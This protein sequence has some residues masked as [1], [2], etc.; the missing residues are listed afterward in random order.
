VFWG[1]GLFCIK[2]T[3]QRTEGREV[4]SKKGKGKSERPED[5][6]GASRESR[7]IGILGLLRLG[8]WRFWGFGRFMLMMRPP[9][10]D[11]LFVSYYLLFGIDDPLLV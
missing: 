6:F 4:K 5:G 1:L 2:K 10:F 11:L 9:G 8:G 3:G 7:W